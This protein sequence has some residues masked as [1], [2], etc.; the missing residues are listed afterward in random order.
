MKAPL[1]A[2][3]SRMARPG[4]VLVSAAEIRNKS[5]PSKASRPVVGAFR[6]S[7]LPSLRASRRADRG[8]ELPSPRTHRSIPFQGRRGALLVAS[9]LASLLVLLGVGSPAHAVVQAGDRVRPRVDAVDSDRDG[10]SDEIESET[11]TDPF[12]P[13]TDDDLVPDGVEDRDRDGR[14]DPG[15]RDPRRAGLH[16]TK[17]RIPEPM[18]F[19]LVRSL[20]ARAGELEA[21]TLFQIDLRPGAPEFRFAPEMEWAP[22][23]GFALELELPFVEERLVAWKTGVQWTAPSPVEA[24]AHGVQLLGEISVDGESR[25]ATALYLAGL[26]RGRASF[27]T[28]LGGRL[29]EHGPGETLGAFLWNPSVYWDFR[30]WLS[31]G[32]ETNVAIDERAHVSLRLLPQAHWQLGDN[33]R[34]QFGGGASY[35]VDRWSPAFA[36]RL[37]VE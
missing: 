28:M 8:S 33:L 9:G 13:D 26:R 11:G 20:G 29:G 22:F 31:L 16:H 15:E 18:V 5:G 6:I 1:A 10:I 37:I 23:D 4:E 35:F 24:F 34:I 14:V 30:E 27:F 12:D 21:N 36:T 2:P 3:T 32:F 17:A 25:D 19:D 7:S